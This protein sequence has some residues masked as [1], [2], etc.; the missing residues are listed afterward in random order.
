MMSGA[1]ILVSGLVQGVCFRDFTSSHATAL[2]L[3]GWVR[4]LADGRVEAMVEGPKKDIE[5][6][7]GLIRRGPHA[8]RVENVEVSWNDYTDSFKDFRILW[9]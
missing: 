9:Q 7:L 2:K 3:T 5:T 8:A 4:N 1:R 6:L